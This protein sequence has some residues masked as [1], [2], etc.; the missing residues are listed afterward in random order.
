[1]RL[2][3]AHAAAGA[4]TAVV[5]AGLLAMP[6]RLLGPDQAR[7]T[8]ISLPRA[9][10]TT[11]V[12]AARPVVKPRAKVVR[13]AAQPAATAQLASVVVHPTVPTRTAPV[14]HKA[15][16]HSE[17]RVAAARV[18]ILNRVRRHP[19]PVDEP[20]VVPKPAPSPGARARACACSRTGP[21]AGTGSHSAGGDTRRRSGSGSGACPGSRRPRRPRR[22][23]SSPIPR[24]PRTQTTSSDSQNCPRDDHHG[25][26]SGHGDDNGGHDSDYGHDDGN[27]GGHGGDGDQHG[28][29]Y[30]HKK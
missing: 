2:S 25:N 8:P 9:A 17:H 15:V 22:R 3:W 7:L 1:M 30:G 19:L 20:R 14:A 24:A 18:T 13:R 29:G 27:H 6:S 5:A 23:G 21:R 26:G 28:H 12:V 11:V 10:S 16:R 4:L